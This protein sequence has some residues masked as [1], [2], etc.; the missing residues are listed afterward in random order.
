MTDNRCYCRMLGSNPKKSGFLGSLFRPLS[1]VLFGRVQWVFVALVGILHSTHVTCYVVNAGLLRFL[2]ALHGHCL[3]HASVASCYSF[4]AL[5]FPCYV[6]LLTLV[7]CSSRCLAHDTI[8]EFGYATLLS[9]ATCY[10]LDFARYLGGS[11]PR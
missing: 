2:L 11:T 5:E 4:L 7:P 8:L 3:L 6:H 9:C 1:K 10:P